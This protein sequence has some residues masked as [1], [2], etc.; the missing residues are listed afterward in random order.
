MT[1]KTEKTE[2]VVRTFDE[3]GKLTREVTTT[4]ITVTPDDAAPEQTGQYL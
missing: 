3:A 2:T 4:V 1:D